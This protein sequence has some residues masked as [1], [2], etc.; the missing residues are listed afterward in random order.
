MMS[1]ASTMAETVTTVMRGAYSRI[2]ARVPRNH[3]RNEI[4]I[5]V[6]KVD[7]IGYSPQAAAEE[8]P[9]AAR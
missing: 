5:I 7:R 1:D 3:A 6:S 9:S 2:A 4:A 8:A